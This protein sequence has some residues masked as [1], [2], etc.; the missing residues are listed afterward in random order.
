MTECVILFRNPQSKKVG[1]VSS[2]EDDDTIAVFANRDEA[3]K[4]AFNVPVCV[5]YPW[6][7]VELD[8]L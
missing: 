3:I 5:V 6:Q 4:A 8:E 7:I 1:W 2:S